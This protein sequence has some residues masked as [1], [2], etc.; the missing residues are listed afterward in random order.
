MKTL[1]SKWLPGTVLLF[2]ISMASGQVLQSC[3]Q[4]AN[5]TVNGYN[6]YNNI[7]GSGAGTQCITVY[8]QANW[9]VDANH[10]DNGG[11]KSYPNAE[12]PMD[13]YVNNMGTVTSSF[14]VTRPS[15]GSYSTT[16][17]IWYD[18]YA[19]E[20]MLWMNYTGSVGPISYSYGCSGYPST[21]CPQATN[22]T[23]GGHTWNIYRGTNGSNQVFSFLRT[24]NTN[25]GTVDI[26]AISQWLKNNGWFGNA[27]LHS[28]QLGFE[29][30]GT[31]GTQRYAVTN[32][33]VSSSAART[34]DIST[35][36]PDET[37]AL[38]LYPN[39]TSGSIKIQLPASSAGDAQL[40]LYN[41]LGQL[42]MSQ[43]LT[44]STTTMDISA[45]KAGIYIAQITTSS[46]SKQIRLIRQ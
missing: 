37:E 11:I 10:P 29:I 9:Y 6:V 40:Q 35:E 45:L 42:I 5:T 34:T 17:D 27:H 23:V 16:Y 43:T 25:S 7:W 33:S 14:S 3:Y 44:E 19:Y 2:S 31:S 12:K 20:I 22:V 21:A 13:M 26:K 24:S 32:Y 1:L 4:W 36:T 41:T 46:F 30:S 15:G 18:N 28:V 38:L 39:P 8:S